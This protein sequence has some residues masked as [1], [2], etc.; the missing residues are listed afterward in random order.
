[1]ATLEVTRELASSHN[2]ELQNI[3]EFPGMRVLCW[4]RNVLYASR[5]YELFSAKVS[6]EGN[7]GDWNFVGRYR[8]GW[9][10]GCTSANRLTSRLLRDGFHALA[11]LSTGH[12]AGAVPGHIVRCLPGDR[13]FR[14]CH[15]VLRGMRPLHIT[16]GPNDQL[17]FGEYFDN[18]ERSE[19]NIYGSTDK[20]ENWDTVYTF[21]AGSIR[22]I[23]NIVF[24]EWANCYWVLTGDEAH[25]PQVLKASLDFHDV[26][27]VISGSQQARAATLVPANNAVYFSTDT[28][29]ERNHVYQFDRTGELTAVSEISGSSIYGCAVNGSLFFTTMVESSEV[30]SDRNVRL[31]ASADG[32]T[33]ESAMVWTK[34]HWPMRFFQYGNAFLPDGINTTDLLAVTTI[35]V[36]G[37]DMITSLYRVHR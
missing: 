12:L 35:A 9:F 26:E 17:L 20:G 19:V 25:E 5:G 30:N 23:H 27:I 14:S 6:V 29:S 32:E 18:Q 22:H 34:D 28:P 8:R 1:M 36:R 37:A 4:D 21:P 24:D 2:V 11:V 15:R 10:R 16:V 3:A 13:E 33:W 31:Y 7:L